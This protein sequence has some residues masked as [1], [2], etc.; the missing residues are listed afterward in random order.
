MR[1]FYYHLCVK[2]N[3]VDII[4]VII[5]TNQVW[6]G[7]LLLWLLESTFQTHGAHYERRYVSNGMIHVQWSFREIAHALNKFWLVES[8]FLDTRSNG[9]IYIAQGAV[10]ANQTLSWILVGRKLFHCAMFLLPLDTGHVSIRWTCIALHSVRC[11][12]NLSQYKYCTDVD[13]AKIWCRLTSEI[14]TWFLF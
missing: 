7:G 6:P 13:W 11:V 3:S 10:F 8:W 9:S 4:N 5:C 1:A 2:T 12:D 14:Y